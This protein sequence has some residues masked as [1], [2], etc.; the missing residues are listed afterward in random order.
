[1]RACVHRLNCAFEHLKQVCMRDRHCTSSCLAG[2]GAP[3]STHTMQMAF[4]AVQTVK[5]GLGLWELPDLE[6]VSALSKLQFLDDSLVL[7][8]LPRLQELTG[9]SVPSVRG[10]L[11]VEHCDNLLDL[12]GLEVCFMRHCAQSMHAVALCH[13]HPEP[14]LSHCGKCAEP[15]G[16]GE[17]PVGKKQ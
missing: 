4:L 9:M 6:S 1:M 12:H 14:A 15:E 16:S 2:C 13:L 11:I 10:D 3:A 8:N 7:Y 17:Q 5:G